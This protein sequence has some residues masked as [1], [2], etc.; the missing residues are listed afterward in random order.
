MRNKRIVVLLSS[1]L[2]VMLLP[3]A[4][5]FASLNRTI[6]P[7]VSTEWLADNSAGLIILDVRSAADYNA[8]HIPGSISEPFVFAP[9]SKWVPF[10]A[11]GLF[12]EVPQTAGLFKTI[13]NLGITSASTVV[14]VTAPNPAPEPPFY[15]LSS[16]TR[17]GDTL[18]YAGVANVAVLD[19]GYPKWVADGMKTTTAASVPT[20]VT[21]Q[22]KVNG[23]IFVS[24]DY[25]K[26]SAKNAVI[27]DGRDA[28]VY[29]GIVIEK[30]FADKAGHIPGAVSL[31]APW[32]WDLNKG[33]SYA[34]YTYKGAETL[35]AMVSGALGTPP[36][37]RE[38]VVYCGVGGYASTLWFVMSQVL[39]Y[40]NVKFYD[41][42][43][44]EWARTNAMV[45]YQWH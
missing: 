12:L 2:I 1:F 30:M 6:A 22:G 33:E 10:G 8:G 14:V 20:P 36:K 23:D 24:M 21:F 38:I 28:D 9:D 41:G 40:E 15:G 16:A 19:G 45:P 29:F 3:G 39:G 44:Q 37:N 34:Y 32:I 31:P 27:V 42:S 5:V 4:A 35:G 25:V 26:K 7:I 11:E 17:I 18:I 13:G 43:A